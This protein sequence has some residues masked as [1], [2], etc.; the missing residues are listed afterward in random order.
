MHALE[1]CEFKGP[2]IKNIKF[3]IFLKKKKKDMELYKPES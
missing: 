2:N 3:T 1:I